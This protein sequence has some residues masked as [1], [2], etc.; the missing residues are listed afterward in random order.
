MKKAS[1]HLAEAEGVGNDFGLISQIE[2]SKSTCGSPRALKAAET[3]EKEQ[4]DLGG[5]FPS[6]FNRARTGSGECGPY[7]TGSKS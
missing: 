6:S 2:K 4:C 3:Q 5:R 1:A 7:G